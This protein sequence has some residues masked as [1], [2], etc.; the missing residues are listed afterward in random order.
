MLNQTSLIIKGED[1]ESLYSRGTSGTTYDPVSVC[2]PNG[3]TQADQVRFAPWGIQSRPGYETFSLF[4]A[5]SNVVQ[6][7]PYET[8]KATSLSQPITGYFVVSH[9][10]GNTS[11]YDSNAA[12]PATPIDTVAGQ[13]FYVSLITIYNRIAFTYHDYRVGAG[14]GTGASTYQVYKIGD[15]ASRDNGGG[16]VDIT[17]GPTTFVS[18][19]TAGNVTVGQHIFGVIGVTS[20]GHIGRLNGVSETNVFTISTANKSVDA[21]NIPLGGAEVTERWILASR[22]I[23]GTYSGNPEDYEVFFVTKIADNVTTSL[24]FNFTDESLVDSADYLYDLASSLSSGLNFTFYAERLI[25]WGSGIINSN[26]VGPHVLRIS[27]KGKPESVSDSHGY[28]TVFPDDGTYGIVNAWEYKGLLVIQKGNKTLVTRD[29]GD[30]PNTWEVEIVD[31]INGGLLYG[32][33]RAMS[34]I[35]STRVDYSVFLN[36]F[37]VQVFDGKVADIPLS[38]KIDRLWQ[39]ISEASNFYKFQIIDIPRARLFLICVLGTTEGALAYLLA[40]DYSK[41]LSWQTVRWSKWKYTDNSIAPVWIALKDNTNFLMVDEQGTDIV[42]TPIGEVATELLEDAGSDISGG[43]VIT[44][45]L[46][47]DAEMNSYQ[48]VNIRMRGRFTAV[49]ASDWVKDGGSTNSLQAIP[50]ARNLSSDVTQLIVK[51][52]SFFPR[53]KLS[54]TS[55][56]SNF[57][58]LKRIAVFGNKSTSD[59]VN[60]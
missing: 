44:G 52:T 54:F 29:N 4:T 56:N 2:P 60:P 58:N 38:W 31:G 59:L 14:V 16:L 17:T 25:S 40:C 57:F 39:E 46:P 49:T 22:V 36:S 37:G 55:N 3:L 24:T 19:A 10:G 30:D 23:S 21:A 53:V 51:Q 33:S 26:E 13:T 9:N 43:V 27:E 11:V 6:V 34:Q 5:I 42:N 48:Y 18:S 45:E 47:F 32:V 12:V 20:T 35:G 50:S 41:G 28:L 15:A 7:I 1:I 8:N